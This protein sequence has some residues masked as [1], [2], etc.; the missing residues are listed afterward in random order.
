LHLARAS[1]LRQQPMVRVKLLV[2]AG[3]QA[4]AMGLAEISALCRHK[5]LAQNGRHLV[6]RWPT[7]GAALDAEG[8]QSY[9]KQLRRRYSQ[10]K[11]EHMLQTLGIVMG[12]ERQAYFSDSEYAAALLDTRIEAIAAVLAEEPAKPRRGKERA[13]AATAD[14][15][16]RPNVAARATLRDLLI[17]WAPYAVGLTALAILAFVAFRA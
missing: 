7:I 11:V 4:E 13:G 15:D 10:E 6:R 17:V 14:G 3:V 1:Q 5:V 9:L 2:L 16:R 8:F 12:E